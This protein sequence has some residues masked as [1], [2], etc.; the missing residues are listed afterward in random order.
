MGLADELD[1][2]APF[3]QG[4]PEP[5]LLVPAG[6]LTGAVSM[7]DES[8]HARFSLESGGARARGVAFRT[9]AAALRKAAQEPL[10]TAVGLERREWNGV[11][12]ARVV[13]RGLR[14]TAPGGVHLLCEEP[15]WEAFERA[16]GGSSVPA[17]GDL[18]AREQR[19]RR[20]EGFA[21]VAGELL[22]SGEAVLVACADGPRRRESLE[23]VV[24]GLAGPE[25]LHAVTWEALGR[26]PEIAAPFAHVVALDPAPLP[27]TPPPGGEG[28]LH[29]AWGDPEIQFALGVA[30]HALDL[31]SPLTA[32]YR[33]LRHSPCEGPALERALGGDGRHP[34]RPEH[35][36]LLVRVLGELGLARYE[37]AARAC[38]LLD[39]QRTSLERSPT[40]RDCVGRLAS[41]R[42]RLGADGRH[43]APEAVPAAA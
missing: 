9:T 34:R 13:L 4:N 27:E 20:G 32:L 41:V 16:L 7:G 43:S 28:F 33:E 8:Q 24:A 1:A 18:P 21:G 42:A 19:D 5:T 30:G 2:L 15:F 25:G 40:Y 6:R 35:A 38:T 26:R 17:A 36:A 23:H 22:S 37:S 3:G 29:L 10:D 31:R 12:E 11:V 14:T 39:A